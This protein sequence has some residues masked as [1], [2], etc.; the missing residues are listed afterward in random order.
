[1]GM[2]VCG[3]AL[4]EYQR[5]AR[6]KRTGSRCRQ[7]TDCPRCIRVMLAIPPGSLPRRTDGIARTLWGEGRP[8]NPTKERMK[9][10]GKSYLSV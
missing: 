9:K 4:P 3:H 10:H 7:E 6:A 8:D 1:M 5:I 2:A